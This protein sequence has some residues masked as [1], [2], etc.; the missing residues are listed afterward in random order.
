MNDKRLITDDHRKNYVSNNKSDI[1]FAQ[2]KKEVVKVDHKAMLKEKRT[3][4][5]FVP[6]FKEE[7]AFDKKVQEFYS[8][9]SENKGIK[10]SAGYI[11]KE[12]LVKNKNTGTLNSSATAKERRIFQLNPNIKEDVLSASSARNNK[13][14]EKNS[15]ASQ[16]DTNKT[17]QDIRNDNLVS[18]IFHDPEKT[19][20]LVKLR[21]QSE[22]V[23]GNRK[24]K[25]E[26]SKIE[27]PNVVKKKEKPVQ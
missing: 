18:N 13:F 9:E 24:I 25:E 6:R 20:F 1:F 11:E 2:N 22:H 26:E 23:K 10:S 15:T 12:S 8:K 21:T 19:E 7:T 5:N 3:Q 4:S 17:S 16:Y 27:R 14:F